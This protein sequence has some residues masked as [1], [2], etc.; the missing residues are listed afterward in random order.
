MTHAYHPSI[1]QRKAQPRCRPAVICACVWLHQPVQPPVRACLLSVSANLSINM[2][3]AMPCFIRSSGP[4]TLSTSPYPFSHLTS[5]TARSHSNSSCKNAVSHET[6]P[7]KIA[8]Q[9]VP[10]LPNY[11][12]PTHT[13]SHHAPLDKRGQTRPE[14]ALIT[15]NTPLSWLVH[16]PSAHRRNQPT[17]GQQQLVQLSARL[18]NFIDH[19]L[20]AGVHSTFSKSLK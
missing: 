14:R 9:Y 12:P 2:V 15:H 3:N 1:I 10:L 16:A 19:K 13:P 4:A 8:S 20:L 6:T 5:T 11:Q 17:L 7:K 18:L